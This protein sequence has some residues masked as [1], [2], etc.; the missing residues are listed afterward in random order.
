V[1]DDP[2]ES[3]TYFYGTYNT[4][5]D[6]RAMHNGY[7]KGGLTIDQY[8]SVINDQVSLQPSFTAKDDPPHPI[9][10]RNNGNYFAAFRKGVTLMNDYI[11]NHTKVTM[12]GPHGQP[13]LGGGTS[14]IRI[15]SHEQYET[16]IWHTDLHE[17]TIKRLHNSF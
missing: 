16:I 17:N 8:Y 12:D 6:N 1:K 11:P 3:S 9:T 5:N 7:R 14:D 15:N 2:D 10:L 4:S 13:F